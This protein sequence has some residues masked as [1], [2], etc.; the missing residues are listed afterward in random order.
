MRRAGTFSIED[1]IKMY[2]ERK[3][4]NA[5]KYSS[6]NLSAKNSPVIFSRK[7]HKE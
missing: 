1:K 6:P 2:K 7:Q 3:S 5:W 4:Q